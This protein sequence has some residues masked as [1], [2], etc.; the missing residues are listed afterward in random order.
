M[1]LNR[2]GPGGTLIMESTGNAVANFI[3]GKPVFTTA[4][5]PPG[6]EPAEPVAPG[7]PRHGKV[8]GY[9]ELGCRCAPCLTA[10]ELF[11]AQWRATRKREAEKDERRRLGLGRW[12]PLPE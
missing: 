7:D 9:E 5:A 11:G 10:E 4:V 3:A 6:N 1:I 2:E 12:D 8:A